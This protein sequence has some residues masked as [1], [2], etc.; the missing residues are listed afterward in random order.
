MRPKW[1]PRD[2][3]TPT[4]PVVTPK[5]AQFIN[6]TA[7]NTPKDYETFDDYERAISKDDII[8]YY[9]DTAKHDPPPLFAKSLPDGG[10]NAWASVV[11]AFMI[12]FA[13]IGYMFTWNVFEDVYNHSF[14][15]DQSPVAVRFVGSLQWFFAFFLC[16]V[17]GK[18]V[19]MGLFKYVVP[20]GSAFFALCLFL[21]SITGEEELGKAFV[22]QGVGMGIG[23]GLVF[24]PTIV[25]PLYYF[26]NQKGFAVGVVMSGASLGGMVFPTAL[27]SMIP[28]VG[29]GSAVRATAI[30]ATLFLAAGNAIF[31][32][33][34]LPKQEKPLYPV[35]RLDLAKYSQEKEY[36]YAAG[37]MF[38]TMLFIYY[39]V[40]YLDLIGIENGV[41]DGIAFNAVLI[42][43]LTGI[44]GRIGLGYASDIVGPWNLLVAVSGGL[45]LM[46]FTMST[47][48]GVKS[49]VF[50][51]LFYGA[52]AGAWLSLMATALVSLSSRPTEYGTRI[53]LIF[54][55]SSIAVLFSFLLQSGL[56]APKNWA[57]P[58]AISGLLFMGVTGLAYMSRMLLATRKTSTRRRIEVLQ[59]LFVL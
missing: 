17:G 57:I 55:A 18:L 43:S 35:P 40:M 2:P 41:G 21:L 8:S 19:D 7:Y 59:G 23:M 1:L 44:M 26:K 54:S 32:W 3:T 4:I 31:V 51:S 34:P 29:V 14:M 24:I 42:L 16:V 50:Y 11:G 20:A 49:L 6:D 9:E 37:G 12:Q 15:T 36:I 13:T 38:L 28:H 30:I 46:M 10:L 27:R 39:P 58:S 5:T 53:G 22:F 56:L 45:A 47:I 48:Q 33:R 52:F 25:V